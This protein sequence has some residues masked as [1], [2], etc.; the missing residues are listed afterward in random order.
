MARLVEMRQRSAKPSAARDV[1]ARPRKGFPERECR[2][3]EAG[4]SQSA[5]PASRYVAILDVR[6]PLADA[7]RPTRCEPVP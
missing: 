3:L 1:S 6:E 2:F 5:G 4:V 7:Y